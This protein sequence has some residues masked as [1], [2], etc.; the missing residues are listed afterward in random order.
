MLGCGGQDYSGPAASAQ[1]AAKRWLEAAVAGDESALRELTV[2]EAEDS[3]LADA[4]RIRK[5]IEELSGVRWNGTIPRKGDKAWIATVRGNM[6]TLEAEEIGEE[7]WEIV[8]VMTS[9]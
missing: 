5:N 7:H 3:L 2:D 4:E 1:E 6:I 8:Y 9:D